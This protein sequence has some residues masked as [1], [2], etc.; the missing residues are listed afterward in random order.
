MHSQRQ[1]DHAGGAGRARDSARF[2][3]LFAAA[4]LIT[5]AAAMLAR[6][7]VSTDA[8]LPLMTTLLFTAALLTTGVAMLSRR[9]PNAR[10]TWMD[11]AGIFAAIGIAVSILIEPHQ[12]VRLV[13]TADPQG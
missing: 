5:L 3:L 13:A 11:I 10:I 2:K 1:S 4:L 8:L 9:N 6:R 7:M 12:M